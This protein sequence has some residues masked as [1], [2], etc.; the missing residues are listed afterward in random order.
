MDRERA[1]MLH[2][3]TPVDGTEVPRSPF[4]VAGW[5]LDTAGPLTA[6]LVGI[7]G[8][9]WAD[10]RLGVS[11]PDVARGLPD[12]PGADRAGWR[13]QFD[14]SDWGPDE[15]EITVVALCHDRTG[16]WEM[17]ARVRLRRPR[18]TI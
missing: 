12:F 13:T 9:R 15:V 5:A 7:D 17:P 18:R 10:A 14:L 11:R 1:V 4:L 2:L 3:D 16:R 8:R 6:V